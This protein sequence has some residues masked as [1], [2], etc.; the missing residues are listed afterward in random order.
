MVMVR[1]GAS[2][3][4]AAYDAVYVALAEGLRARLVT[5]DR[6]LATAP[7]IAGSVELV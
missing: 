5:R 3:V 1:A 6:H 4:N 2:E 7:G